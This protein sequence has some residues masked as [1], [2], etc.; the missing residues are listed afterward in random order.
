METFLWLFLLSMTMFIGSFLAGSIPLA[1]HLSED[2]LRTIS[3]FG[4]GLLVGTSLIVIIPEGIETL[5][6]VE[7][8]KVI[9]SNSLLTINNNNFDKRNI[10]NNNMKLR[11][12]YSYNNNIKNFFQKRSIKVEEILKDK[13]QEIEPPIDSPKTDNPSDNPSDNDSDHDHDHD[14]ANHHY[15]GFALISGFAMMFVIDQIDSSHGHNHT[16]GNVVSLTELRSLANSGDRDDEDHEMLGGSSSIHKKPASATIGLVIHA[17]A[18][19]I[20]LGASASQPALELI[21]FLAIML[22]KAPAAFG[23]STILLREA[24]TRRQIR[25]H[26]LTFS[27]AAP[28]SAIIT[29][30]LLQRS[31]EIDPIGMKWWTAVLLL[32]SGGTFLY[33]AM[34]VMQDVTSGNGKDNGFNGHN[35]IKMKKSHVAFMLLGMFMPLL[36]QFEHGHGH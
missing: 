36:L 27:L 4:V 29:Y 26:L 17:A 12:E 30:S 32:F 1:F 14:R 19:G 31:G 7:S 22:H 34:H 6:S 16:R 13:R 11:N 3:A 15:I 33:V 5:Y 2:R 35:I 28:L 10:W 21:V 9:N 23:L 18:D 25:K 8:S 20:A 24:Y